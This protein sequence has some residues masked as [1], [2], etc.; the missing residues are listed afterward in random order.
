MLPIGGQTYIY[1]LPVGGQTYIYIYVD[2]KKF[3]VRFRFYWRP[4]EEF[5]FQWRGLK[6]GLLQLKLY[7]G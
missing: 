2:S 5:Y 4:L 3:V 1:M 6:K 7:A